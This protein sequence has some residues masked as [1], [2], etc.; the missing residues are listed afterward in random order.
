MS[1]NVV[2][3]RRRPRASDF[4]EQALNQGKPLPLQVLLDA[5]WRLLDDAQRLESSGNADDAIIARVAKDRALRLAGEAAPYLHPRMASTIVSGDEDNP[6]N[7]RHTHADRFARLTDEAAIRF[8]KA[9]TAG[10][11]TIEQVDAELG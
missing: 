5:M 6:I 10:E 9:I 2:P 3:L 7:V 1:G 11:M 8:L 4:I